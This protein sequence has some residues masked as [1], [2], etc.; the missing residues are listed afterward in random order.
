MLV[1]VMLL[2]AYVG[3]CI[4]TLLNR[5]S[6]IWFMRRIC[7]FPIKYLCSVIF[8]FKMLPQVSFGCLLI[9]PSSC[10]LFSITL[11]SPLSGVCRC[12]LQLM[13]FLFWRPFRL[14]KH[15]LRYC[16]VITNSDQCRCH[17]LPQNTTL[18]T[19]HKHISDPRSSRP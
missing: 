8:Y 11:F 6:C 1:F 16:F 7:Y 9:F 4:M 19:F 13:G 2:F 3:F 5:A 18:E 14:L 17:L 15:F 10:Q 12:P